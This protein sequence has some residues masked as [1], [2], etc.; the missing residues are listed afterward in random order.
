MPKH[1]QE[2]MRAFAWPTYFIAFLLVA[3]PAAD[4]VANVIPI[5]IGD[6]GWRYGS[7]GILAGFLLTPLFGI[8]FALGSA[9]VL[10]HRLVLRSLSILNLVMAVLIAALIV[11]FALDVV[12]VGAT[13]LDE[14]TA[15]ARS[16]FRIGAVKAILKYLSFAAGLAWLGITGMRV[17]RSRHEGGRKTGKASDVP[18]VRPAE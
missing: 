2:I 14:A 1:S 16:A 13:I 18:L 10:E 4:F 11:L 12:Q 15:E 5:R 8:L 7:V 6:V 3:T 9:V 17:T